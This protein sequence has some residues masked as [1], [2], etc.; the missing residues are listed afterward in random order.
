MPDTLVYRFGTGDGKNVSPTG[1]LNA[2]PKV[3]VSGDG[4]KVET[5]TAASTRSFEFSVDTSGTYLVR[6]GGMAQKDGGRANVSIDGK[7]YGTYGFYSVTGQY[8]RPDQ[9]IQQ[10][11]LTAG[12]TR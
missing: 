11:P 9:Y 1:D 5:T 2:A 7:V 6:L 3:T 4:L 8:P 10:L 12:S